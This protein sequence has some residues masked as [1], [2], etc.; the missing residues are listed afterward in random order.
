MRPHIRTTLSVATFV[1]IAS[2]APA[3][4]L[5]LAPSGF[6]NNIL[7]Q[8]NTATQS[9][10]AAS[11]T[12]ASV[13]FG[14][15][16]ILELLWSF[17]QSFLQTRD[18]DVFIT[19]LIHRIIWCGTCVFLLNVTPS[20]VMPLLQ[21][22]LNIGT[23][24]AQAGGTSTG[25]TPDGV[26]SQGF[27][28]AQAVFNATNN[29]TWNAQLL[30]ILPQTLGALAILLSYALVAAQLLLTE[31]QIFII[32]GAGAFLLGFIGSRWTMPYAELYPRMVLQSGLKLVAI[33][34]VVGLGK[35]IS[36]HMVTQASSPQAT[37]LDY[38]TMGCSC[39]VFAIVAWCVPAVMQA[40]AGAGPAFNAS[41]VALSA[42]GSLS[43]GAPGNGNRSGGGSGGESSAKKS[44]T[45]DAVEK[46]AQ[47][48]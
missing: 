10:L 25:A 39:V 30:E 21:D 35:T 43:R 40:F 31:I 27:Q 15:L 18:P 45:L 3:F 48:D 17:V 6:L 4:S 12:W 19:M 44:G 47:I 34:L 23:S 29:D 24:I 46:A 8:Y 14:G 7:N 22:F 20:I 42:M 28:I 41:G 36:Q 9:W 26:F 11:L 1:L 32:V 38:L 5:P 13:I 16:V 33:T 2:A 37:P